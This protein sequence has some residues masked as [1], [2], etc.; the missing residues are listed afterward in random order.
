MSYCF[1]FSQNKNSML[2]LLQKYSPSVSFS[3]SINEK[4][5]QIKGNR[6]AEMQKGMVFIACKKHRESLGRRK[7]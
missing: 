3:I 1:C 6:D 5:V 7:F 2:P 4:C